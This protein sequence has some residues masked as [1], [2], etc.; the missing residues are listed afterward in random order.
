MAKKQEVTS[1]SQQGDEGN[2]W[3]VN[4]VHGEDSSRSMGHVCTSRNEAACPLK[5]SCMVKHGAHGDSA[6][7]EAEEW[8][9]CRGRAI[10]SGSEQGAK[11]GRICMCRE[12]DHKVYVGVHGGAWGRLSK[13]HGARNALGVAETALHVSLSN[14]A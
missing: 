9:K 10:I 1:G 5:Q 11:R 4:G 6:T 7:N 14:H 13:I 8:T 3:E 2:D 12:D